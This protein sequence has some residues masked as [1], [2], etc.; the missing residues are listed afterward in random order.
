[1]CL[2]GFGVIVSFAFWMLAVLIVDVG[3][4]GLIDL[5][6]VVGYCLV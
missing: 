4:F 2:D 5:I 1:M 6:L 3:L